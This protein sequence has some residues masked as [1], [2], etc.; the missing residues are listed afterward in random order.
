MNPRAEK[1][2]DISWETILKI[3]LAFFIFY[4]IYLVRDILVWF[5]FAIIISLI[6]DPAINFLQKLKIPR[7]LASIFIYVSI[8]GILGLLIYFT[9]PLFISEIQQFSQLFPQ[10]FEKFKQSN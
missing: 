2:L 8:F 1:V 9:V 6:F 3:A 4:I 10:Y 7:L 5:L